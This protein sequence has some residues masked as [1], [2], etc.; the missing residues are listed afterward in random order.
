MAVEAL[1]VIEGFVQFDV[2]GLGNGPE[3]LHHKCRSPRILE[4]MV[5]NMVYSV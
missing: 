2:F 3:V 1:A 5:P 4:F